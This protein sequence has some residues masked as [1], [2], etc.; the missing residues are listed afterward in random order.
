MSLLPC[1][2]I[3]SHPFLQT[4]GK[5]GIHAKSFCGNQGKLMHK[6]E[7]RTE[8]SRGKKAKWT[9][10]GEPPRP[11]RNLGAFPQYKPTVPGSRVRA[12]L[13]NIWAGLRFPQKPPAL[14]YLCSLDVT[15]PAAQEPAGACTDIGGP[16]VLYCQCP[17][18]SVSPLNPCSW[19]YSIHSQNET[20]YHLP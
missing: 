17:A 1:Y 10:A 5:R 6:P 18:G 8:V 11:A 2:D 12:L 7:E 20:F 13:A 16:D 14:W 4:E 3:N 15:S 9:L 19:R